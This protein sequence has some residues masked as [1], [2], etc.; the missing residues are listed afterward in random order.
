MTLDVRKEFGQIF[1]QKRRKLEEREADRQV[2][3]DRH[4]HRETGTDRERHG[5]REKT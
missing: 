4:R 2:D 1:F 3:R 5:E